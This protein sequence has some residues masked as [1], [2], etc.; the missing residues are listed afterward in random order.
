MGPNAVKIF[1]DVVC[2]PDT[3]IWRPTVDVTYLEDCLQSFVSWL[4]NKVV[5]ENAPDAIGHHSPIQKSAS[6]PQSSGGRKPAPTAE[7]S[8]S[9]QQSSGAKSAPTAMQ[10]STAAA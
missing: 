6:T 10:Q 3:F 4:V 7:K 2:Q 8:A 5:F 9:T 1:V